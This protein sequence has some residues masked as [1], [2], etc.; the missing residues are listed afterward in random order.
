MT[1]TIDRTS[2]VPLYSQIKQILIAELR[3]DHGE[4]A[5]TLTEASLINRFHVSR[6]PVRQA[7]KELVDEGY[8]VRQRAK[9]TFPV[10]GLNVRL[11]FSAELGGINRY[12]AE[13]GMKPTSRIVKVARVKAP[14]EVCQALRLQPQEELLHLQRVIFVKG[15]PLVWACTYLCTPSDF[16]PTTE[17]LEQY[18]TVFPLIDKALGIRFI[19]GEQHIW[20]SAAT[21]EEAE[22]LAIEPGS[23][24]LVSVTTMYTSNGYPGG[25]RRAVHPAEDFKYAF[26]LNR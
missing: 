3:G 14:E 20:A 10:R 17:E 4:A 24:V 1:Q 21:A 11:P 16:L 6:A 8:V 22:A 26:N 25:W 23:P 19:H 15:S 7:L 5:P 12:L 9:G 2:T 18:G 13:Q